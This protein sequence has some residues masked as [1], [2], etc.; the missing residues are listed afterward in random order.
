LQSQSCPSVL[1]ESRAPA[2]TEGSG[3]LLRPE[4]ESRAPADTEGSGTLLRPEAEQESD[5]KVIL[6][7]AHRSSMTN[8]QEQSQ[9]LVLLVINAIL[10]YSAFSYAYGL[11]SL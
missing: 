11:E 3:T 7:P 2:D 8:N 10:K 1:E 9:L 5:D 6:K 4:A